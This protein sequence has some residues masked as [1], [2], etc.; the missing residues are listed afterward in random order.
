MVLRM[1]I[2]MRNIL[3]YSV[4]ICSFNLGASGAAFAQSLGYFQTYPLNG[5]V[6]DS[7]H[8]KPI[9]PDK[10]NKPK[11]IENL[12]KPKEI[13]NNMKSK[14]SDIE[15]N[16]KEIKK[17]KPII[18]KKENPNF[19]PLNVSLSKPIVN[20][21]P[22]KQADDLNKQENLILE[23]KKKEEI[24][25]E[26]AKPLNTEKPAL[27]LASSNNANISF[28]DKETEHKDKKQSDI[29]Q[30][31]NNK[32]DTIINDLNKGV[33]NL[34]EDW[35]D[36]NTRPKTREEYAKRPPLKAIYQDSV[37]AVKE[38][39][40]QAVADNLPWVDTMRKQEPLDTVLARVSD[41]LS[42]A[43]ASDPEWVY[44]AQSE[45]RELAQKLDKL[46]NPPQYKSEIESPT[47]KSTI[48]DRKEFRKRPV[49]HGAK[50]VND[51]N[52]RPEVVTSNTNRI[53]DLPPEGVKSHALNPYYDQLPTDKQT[54]NN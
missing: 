10:L 30:A 20:I 23:E 36:L 18:D 12:D 44:P 15:L 29:I 52:I 19:K 16:N 27:E 33:K 22:K 32:D 26:I 24:K 17:Q 25:A 5:E 48:S 9:K 47:V 2:R 34:K 6:P 31:D 7:G 11:N 39:V 51:V 45:L 35:K 38:D 13:K 53:N 21:E 37:K 1:I 42:R 4:I 14:K 50:G 3:T 49:W 54:R 41:N 40:P 28:G 46:S 8:E 43:N